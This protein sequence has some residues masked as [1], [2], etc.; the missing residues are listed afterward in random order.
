MPLKATI[1]NCLWAASN[2]PAYVRFRRALREPQ[3]AQRRKLSELITQNADTAFGKTYRFGEIRSYED[4]TRHV[5]LS[6]Y[7]DLEPWIDRIRRG[8]QNVL[9]S[10]LVT[11][12]VPTSGSTGAR[13]LIPFTA[14]LQREFNAA[15]GPWLVD[16]ARCHA[17]VL[18]GPAYWSITPVMSERTESSAVPIGFAS[19]TEY[20][21]G[22][23]RRLAEAIM[24]V[25]ASVSCATSLDAFRYETLLHLVRCRELRLISVWHPSFL[26][27]LL[28]A[29]PAFWEH[30]MKVISR[31]R[32]NE[33]R[34]AEPLNPETIWP[35]LRVISCWGEGA[36]V[37]ALADLRKRFPTT[38]IQAKGLLATEA[39]VTLPFEHQYPLAIESHFF[40]FIDSQG[41]AIPMEDV[42]EGEE[43][44]IVVTTAGGLWRYRLG[45]RVRVT[46]WLEKTPSLKFLGRK[47]NVSDRFGEK[48]HETFVGE[49]LFEVFG[50]KPA[51]F[52]MLAP[53]EDE[54]GCR[55]TLY[56]EGEAELH[57]SEELDEALRR[58]PHYAYCRD[59]GQLLPP[60]IFL[61]TGRGFESFAAHQAAHGSRLGE[62]KPV[63]LVAAGGWSKLFSG[64]YLDSRGSRFR[65]SGVERALT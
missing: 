6:D 48:L 8:E 45:D 13:K 34:R 14:G 36:A 17:G 33:L 56:V 18:G 60:R 62:I 20:L 65:A 42:R 32:T 31:E 1:A 58:N 23:R 22:N 50:H 4:F 41:A 52:A 55:Y 19:D 2:L 57:W 10:D 37:L 5:P 64:A 24:A 26:T 7:S 39:F 51:R 16:L 44:E 28:D 38:C 49:V 59:L 9:T 15:I 35:N 46:G 30:L 25:P 27:L 63:S 61:I 12:L 40:E 53:D 43:Y 3:I 11:H 29:L 21:G 47:G 54:Q